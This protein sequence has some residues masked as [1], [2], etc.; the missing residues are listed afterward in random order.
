MERVEPMVITIDE[1]DYTLEFNRET[2]AMAENSGFTRDGASDKMM[3]LLPD[4]FFF[5]FKMHH[6]TIKREKTDEILFKKL[7]GLRSEEIERL[8]E[9]FD[10]PYKS[11]INIE[12]EDERKN[13]GVT[14]KL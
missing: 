4:L 3:T 10:E 5:A 13:S 12:E 11:L 8:I 14:V 1:K 7:K 6:P 2:V 9:L